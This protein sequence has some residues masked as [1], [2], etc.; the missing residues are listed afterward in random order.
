MDDFERSRE[1]AGLAALMPHVPPSPEAARKFLY[2]FHGET[3]IV[4]A[5]QYLPVRQVS[6]IPLERGTAW[7]TA[8]ESGLVQELGRRCPL[9]KIATID[10]DVIMIESWKKQPTRPIR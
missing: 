3:I 6:Y 8:S 4:E 7:V 5:Q 9:Q 1:D 2:A 10:L